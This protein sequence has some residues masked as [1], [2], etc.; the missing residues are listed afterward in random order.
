M[1][2]SFCFKEQFI[3]S[4]HAGYSMQTRMYHL[5]LQIQHWMESRRRDWYCVLKLNVADKIYGMLGCQSAACETVER[6]L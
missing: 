2:L 1:F 5:I 3:E 4:I 6:V